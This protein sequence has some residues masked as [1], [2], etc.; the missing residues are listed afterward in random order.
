LLDKALDCSGFEVSPLKDFA[1]D[2]PYLADWRHISRVA[3]I[4]AASLFR[5]GKQSEAF[6]LSM[7]IV[8]LGQM[9]EDSGGP[10]LHYLVGSAVK[11]DGLKRLREMSAKTALPPRQLISYASR[12]V[13]Q[14]ANPTGLTNAFK[15]EYGVSVKACE[16]IR[17]GK[18]WGTNS[19]AYQLAMSAGMKPVFSLTK[20]KMLLARS[21]RVCLESIPRPFNKMTLQE[22]P[23]MPTNASVLRMMLKGNAFGEMW[24]DMMLPSWK[25]LLSRK[26]QENITVSATQLVLALKAYHS[27]HGTLPESLDEL[28]PH[29]IASVPLDDFDG[30]RLRY[31]K[32]KKL[33]WSI[34]SDLIDSGGQ[35]FNQSKQKL[36]LPF[37]IEF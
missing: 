22:L 33:I 8:R 34:G 14:K 29:Y 20:T 2:Y 1:E 13:V 12:L 21:S 37:R 7:K 18:S 32:E 9:M 25:H 24:V 6:D 4:Q 10:I 36:D 27:E 16:D 5:Q 35:E 19:M 28:V 31:S 30:M 15:A 23:L 17:S 11:A 26:C 3:S